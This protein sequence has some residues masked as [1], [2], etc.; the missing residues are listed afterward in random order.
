MRKRVY[1]SVHSG[2]ISFSETLESTFPPEQGLVN[3][4]MVH[5]YSGVVGGQIRIFEEC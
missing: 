1:K 2:A 3:Q 5:P 4:I